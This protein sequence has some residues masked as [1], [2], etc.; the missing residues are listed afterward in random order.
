[1]DHVWP[2]WPRSDEKGLARYVLPK[3]AE[4]VRLGLN[5]FDYLKS[6]RYS[7][8][9][10]GIY[11]TV[12]SLDLRYA[13]EP[14]H[15]HP[16]QQSLR[17][18]R[19]I[20][21]GAQ[22]GTCIDLALL[23]AALCLG[24][25][26]VPL[27]VIIEGHA[28]AAVSLRYR[29]DEL[30]NLA[31]LRA[32]PDEGDGP[33]T[34]QGIL[35]A[36]DADKL[37]GL[38]DNGYYLA[39]ECTGFAHSTVLDPA[40][41]EGRGRI[42]GRLDF[43]R[44]KEAG[45][46][47]LDVS[48]RPFLFAIDPA[49]L[50]D[51]YGYTPYM[52]P[53][54]QVPQ[55]V[56][57]FDGLFDQ[58]ALFAGRAEALARLTGLVQPG[59]KGRLLVLG[60]SGMGKTAL[61]VNWLRSLLK[62]E[63][64]WVVYH[65]MSRQPVLNSAGETSLLRNLCQQLMR[66]RFAPDPIPGELDALRLK[67]LELLT[68]YK[69]H[70]PLTV[71]VDGL[72]EAEGWKP[73]ST[74]HIPKTLPDNVFFITSA[75]PIADYDW[76]SK[77]QFSENEVLR[78]GALSDDD[79]AMLLRAAGGAA[80]ALADDKAFVKAL[81]DKAE[82]DP[83]FLRLVA[84][85]DILAGK[86]KNEEAL[87][88]L[89][90]GLTDYLK[91]WWDEI[92]EPVGGEGAVRELVGYL[93]VAQGALTYKDLAEIDPSESALLRGPR[94]DHAI[95]LVGRFLIGNED[96]GYAL[97]HPRFREFLETRYGS[98]VLRNYRVKLLE[99]CAHWAGNKSP[100]AIRFFA[101]HL[102]DEIKKGIKR[103]D[104]AATNE[105]FERLVELLANDAFQATYMEEVGDFATLGQ[106][107]REALKHA[108]L[109]GD[110]GAVPI[111][112]LPLSYWRV[113]RQWLRA[114]P[115]L[116]AAKQGQL[117]EAERR[118]AAFDVNVFWRRAGLLTIAWL[119]AKADPLGARAFLTRYSDELDT[120]RLAFEAL[121]VLRERVMADLERRSPNEPPPAY[122]PESLPEGVHE[123][124]AAALVDRLGG[125]IGENISGLGALHTTEGIAYLA[126][127]EVPYLVAFA[128]NQPQLGLRLLHKYV[129]AHAAN[130]YSEYRDR[131]LQSI[132]GPVLCLKEPQQ[133]LEF[134]QVLLDG[135]FRPGGVPYR[136]PLLVATGALRA[137]SGEKSAQASLDRRR[138]EVLSRT[139]DLG[140]GRAEA[141]MWGHHCRRLALLAE[142]YAVALDDTLTSATLLQTASDLP[143]GYAGFQ[144]PASLTLAEATNVALGPATV[145][146][147]AL[148]QAKRSAYFVQEPP[149]CVVMT[150]R[151]NAIDKNWWHQPITS[152]PAL[153]ERFTSEPH[154]R[155]FASLHFVRSHPVDRG[156]DFLRFPE[157]VA[158]ADTLEKIGRDVFRVAVSDLETL[159]PT[160]HRNEILPPGTP[161]NV[162]DSGLAA[163][164]AQ[165]FAAEALAQ[166]HV[167]GSEAATLIGRLVPMALANETALH[168]VLA[169]MLL[170]MA[171]TDL[172]IL[173]GIGSIAPS[174]WM[175]E[176]GERHDPTHHGRPQPA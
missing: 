103:G 154:A 116:E 76:K 46:E 91:T 132:L 149:F 139:R 155:E 156:R 165:R 133:P 162:P 85:P 107:I 52:P 68:N 21:L 14:P 150:A 51:R 164:L 50:Q 73:D 57:Q 16:A 167:L 71:V 119:G 102:L 136:E 147:N 106:D 83:L 110:P 82:G 86:Y 11:E 79:V 158:H 113:R 56:K 28:L 99:Y 8:L 74:N 98:G 145:R 70:S 1:M 138:E 69:L 41:P 123:D 142:A 77:L 12:L 60:D 47:Q 141:D 23:F 171:P 59:A 152:V 6:Q 87:G 5:R 34:R 39:V 58:H 78:L 143:Y 37:K 153:I 174:D 30:D 29:Y 172:A 38:I 169:R 100:Y 175:Q 88:K 151:V 134:L 159:N 61:L 65:I 131:A 146:D 166:R 122:R 81:C 44:A 64:L 137:R 19:A 105:I 42:D 126:E 109:L 43:A 49:V 130:P 92:K 104:K 48:S 3:V 135:A 20:R 111:A 33:W 84:I 89:P 97:C 36:G 17:D 115:L 161:V 54:S 35:E 127:R 129:D 80:T 27:V 7:D 124:T 55:L 160:M 66:F 18:P 75:R 125:R 45:R 170:A 108:I 148:A 176:A 72:D 2:P 24:V 13:Y 90:K 67:Y 9:V 144:A 95:G 10:R 101:R 25:G 22:E 114:G 173:D 96:D 4:S 117:Q 93:T 120:D 53:A 163:L 112:R 26:L 128:N 15:P 140:I 31:N 40:M 168:L 63:D 121:H 118:L 94:R 157:E 32:D 62:R